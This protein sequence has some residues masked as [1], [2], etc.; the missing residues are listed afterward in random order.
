M[1]MEEVRWEGVFPGIEASSSTL[2]CKVPSFSAK[3][4]RPSVNLPA[5]KHLLEHHPSFVGPVRRG[6]GKHYL[7][8]FLLADL[9]ELMSQ[10]TLT[11]G[12]AACFGEK[13][14]NH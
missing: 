7:S 4:V 2:Q 8:Q 5:N 12:G 6:Y 10:M 11:L 3:S 14:T 9:I 1:L 13:R